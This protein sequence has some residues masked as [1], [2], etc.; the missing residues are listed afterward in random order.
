MKLYDCGVVPLGVVPV[1]LR[2]VVPVIVRGDW[3]CI[4]QEMDYGE[5]PVTETLVLMKLRLFA[6]S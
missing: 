1:S 2:G 6:D 4:L 3:N 5:Q